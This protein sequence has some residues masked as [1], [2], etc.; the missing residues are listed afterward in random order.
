M[1]HKRAQASNTRFRVVAGPGEVRQVLE[2]LHLD[3]VLT[4]YPRLDVAL[5]TSD[6][7]PQQRPR[8]LSE[9]VKRVAFHI[10]HPHRESIYQTGSAT[11]AASRLG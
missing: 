2:I 11:S 5:L 6:G 3:T 7:S 10:V 9:A 1:A 8:L 4:V